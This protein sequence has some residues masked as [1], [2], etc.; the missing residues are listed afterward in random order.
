MSQVRA[1]FLKSSEWDI[2]FSCSPA[3]LKDPSNAFSVARVKK[4]GTMMAQFRYSEIPAFW[5][6][7]DTPPARV[8]AV[9][10][11]IA[12]KSLISSCCK[13]LMLHFLLPLR[14]WEM[15]AEQD[16]L[17]PPWLQNLHHHCCLKH[18]IL[19]SQGR[20]S[21]EQL[22]NQGLNYKDSV[23]VPHTTFWSSFSKLE[24]N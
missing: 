19:F 3:A 16:R 17:A 21:W 22:L 14:I 1:G 24:A 7:F 11:N 12:G 23:L 4:D 8:V 9:S 6:E 13:L 10:P 2:T 18:H 20:L 15:E 5:D